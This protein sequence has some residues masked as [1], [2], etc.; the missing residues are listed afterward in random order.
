MKVLQ[1]VSS[2]LFMTVTEMSERFQYYKNYRWKWNSSFTFYL[3]DSDWNLQLASFV[4]KKIKFL[5]AVQNSFEFLNGS[6]RSCFLLCKAKQSYYFTCFRR[7]FISR[8]LLYKT[9]VVPSESMEMFLNSNFIGFSRMPS[10]ASILNHSLKSVALFTLHYRLEKL[11]PPDGRKVRMR[12]EDTVSSF[13]LNSSL[14]PGN[15]FNCHLELVLDSDDSGNSKLF[16]RKDQFQKMVPKDL[17][18]EKAPM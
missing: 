3:R 9:N 16:S 7:A 17:F 18:L 10:I 14:V 12:M 6:F 8:L 5:F 13:Q 4:E 1:L 11:C 15:L 2:L